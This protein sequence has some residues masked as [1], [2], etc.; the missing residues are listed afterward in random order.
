[1]EG[2]EQESRERN[3]LQ[4]RTQVFTNVTLHHFGGGA[5]KAQ[6][7]ADGLKG[8]MSGIARGSH[9]QCGPSAIR[10]S[11]DAVGTLAAAELFEGG[12]ALLQPDI[13][14]VREAEPAA[15]ILEAECGDLLVS[16]VHAL[17]E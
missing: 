16:T 5:G 12:H 11:G 8:F 10:I 13:A 2:T 1:M 9:Q 3:S 14:V 4:M 6:C 7:E 15:R 17:F